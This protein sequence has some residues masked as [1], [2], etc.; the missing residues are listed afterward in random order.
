M[1]ALLRSGSLETV[2][3]E[4]EAL[5]GHYLVSCTPVIDAEGSIQKVIHL[6]TDI[7]ERKQ[8]EEALRVSEEKY[9]HLFEESVAPIFV[10]LVDGTIIG[11]QSGLR[12]TL[13]VHEKG[14]FGR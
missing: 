14:A 11:R 4:M 12:R 9:R 6:A 2:E 10:T 1:E 7:T 3:M 13:R 5:G 8:T